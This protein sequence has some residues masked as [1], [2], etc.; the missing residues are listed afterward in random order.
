MEIKFAT[1]HL[2]FLRVTLILLSHLLLDLQNCLS[3][4]GF[5]IKILEVCLL[6]SVTYTSLQK[7]TS[8]SWIRDLQR[9]PLGLSGTLLKI[10]IKV[11]E[12]WLL[13]VV[14]HSTH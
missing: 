6:F 8:F 2:L 12:E 1:F 4:K 11:T 5:P 3:P 7:C 14:D 13:P 10:E 9:R